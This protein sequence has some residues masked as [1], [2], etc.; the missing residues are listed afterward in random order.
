MI[1]K[2]QG[3]I[4]SFIVFVIYGLKVDSENE[5]IKYEETKTTSKNV[6]TIKTIKTSQKNGI[7]LES[8]PYGRGHKI[9]T[10]PDYYKVFLVFWT[11]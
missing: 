9:Q 7:S 8:L 6:K 2:V 5:N 3:G 4:F 11:S 1:L 10:Y